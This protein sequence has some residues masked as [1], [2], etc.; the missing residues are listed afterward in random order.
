MFFLFLK[1]RAHRTSDLTKKLEKVGPF[2]CDELEKH[3]RVSAE[4]YPTKV[5]ALSFLKMNTSGKLISEISRNCAQDLAIFLQNSTSIYFL[6]FL[7]GVT[8]VAWGSGLKILMWQFRAIP[9]K[10]YQNRC[11]TRRSSLSILKNYETSSKN[12]NTF[13]PKFAEFM[14]LTFELTLERWQQK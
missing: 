2:E 10:L 6:H 13:W 4:C 11:E 5:P 8:S 1:I 9:R 12:A 7:R 3:C 14:S